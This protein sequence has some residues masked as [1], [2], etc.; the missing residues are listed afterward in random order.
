MKLEVDRC[1]PTIAYVDLKDTES[2][3]KALTLLP[4]ADTLGCEFVE[5]Y[6][7][8]QWRVTYLIDGTEVKRA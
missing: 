8:G 2:L 5:V 6:Q 7:D 4:K 3:E 1:A